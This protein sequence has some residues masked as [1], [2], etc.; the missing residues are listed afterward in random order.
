MDFNSI[1]NGAPFY[2]LTKSDKPT[3]TIGVVKEKTAP[4]PKYQTPLT[5]AAFNGTQPQTFVTITATVNGKDETFSDIPTNV[6]IA[7][8]G[9]DVFSGS[10]EAMLQFVDGMMQTSKKALDM[11]DY[12]K[13]VLAEGEKML[14]TLNPR[15][16]DE[17]RQAKTIKGLEEHQAETDKKLNSLEQMCAKMLNILNQFNDAPPEK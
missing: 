5:P 7:Q 12:H 10:R 14:E 11:V 1:G 15:Y 8:K 17:K 4:Q 9:N 16:A 2:V 6:E 13:S 3:L